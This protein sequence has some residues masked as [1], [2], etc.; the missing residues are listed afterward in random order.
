MADDDS[1]FSPEG[2]NGRA[3]RHALGKFPD[4][5]RASAKSPAMLS[6]LTNDSNFVGH[7]N[8]NYAREL[9]ELFTLGAG[10]GYTQAD[11]RAGAAM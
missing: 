9:M 3:Y 11:V 7:P 5:L 2:E 8:E 6:Y 4:M 1:D 10:N